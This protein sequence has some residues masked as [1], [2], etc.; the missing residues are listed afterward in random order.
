MFSNISFHLHGNVQDSE[1]YLKGDCVVHSWRIQLKGIHAHEEAYI[2][3][4][5]YQL[6][7]RNQIISPLLMETPR[8]EAL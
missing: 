2:T 8:Q 6:L 3:N 5:G 4:L 1:T 7:P